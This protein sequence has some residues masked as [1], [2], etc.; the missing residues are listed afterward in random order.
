MTFRGE[1]SISGFKWI[2]QGGV[3]R[4]IHARFPGTEPA[5]RCSLGSVFI[6]ILAA[7]D[8]KPFLVEARVHSQG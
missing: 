5:K 3:L 8:F 4:V 1:G 7:L 6:C 2:L